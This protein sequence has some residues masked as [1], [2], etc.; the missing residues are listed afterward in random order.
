MAIEKAGR[1]VRIARAT[2][3]DINVSPVCNAE[4]Q[5]NLCRKLR[6]RQRVTPGRVPAWPQRGG[7]V[8]NR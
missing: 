4:L 5:L 1:G 2:M 7:K 6:N 8:P 3:L